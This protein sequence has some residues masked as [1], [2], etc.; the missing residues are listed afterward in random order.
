M[1]SSSDS[2]DSRKSK[3]KRKGFKIG[4]SG[5]PVRWDGEDWTFYKHAMQNAFE[6]NFLDGIAKFDETEDTAWDDVKKEE[7]K[8]KQAEIKILIQGSLSMRLAK[9]VMSKSTGTEMWQELVTIYEGK[10]NPAMTAQKVYRLQRELRRTNLR[11]KDDVRGHLYKLF[12]IKTQLEDLGAPVN[13]LQ[14]VDRMLRSLPTAPCYNELRRKKSTDWGN[15]AFGNKQGNTAHQK[16]SSAKKG[17]KKQSSGGDPNKKSGK[18]IDHAQ[19]RDVVVGDVVKRVAKDYDPSRWYFDTGSNAYITACKEY[20]TSMQSMENSD[21]NPTISGFA[22]GV[23]AKAE[24][25]GTIMLAAMIDEKMVFLLVED[26]LYVP[27]AGCNLFSPGLALDQGFQMTWDSDARMFGMSKEGTEVIRTVYENRLWTFNAHNIGSAITNKKKNAVKKHVFANFAITDGVE[28]IDVWHERLGHTCPEYIRLMVDRGMAKG[29]MLKRRGKIDCADCHFG[30]QRRKT[31]KKKLGR[32]IEKVNDI[33]Y[34]DLLIPGANNGSQYSAVLVVMDGFSRYVKIFLLKSKAEGEVNKYMQEYIAWAERQHG[35]RVGT[36][37]TREWSEDDDCEASKNLVRQ[38]LTDK[39]QEFC[40]G[41]MAKWYK[42]KGIVHTKVGP[43]TS[44][45][46]PVERTH[47]TLVDMVKTMMHQSGLPASFWT[48]ALE[49][50][51]YVKN[52]VFC[53]GA[54]CTPYEMMFDSKPDIHH[55]RA[56]GSLAYCYTPKSKLKKFAMNCKMGFLIGYR[57]DVVG[58]RV[59]FPTEHKK[60][61]VSDVKINEAIKYKDRHESGYKGKVNK[62]LQTFNEFINEGEFDNFAAVDHDGDDS[63]HQADCDAESERCASSNIDMEDIE[64]VAGSEDDNAHGVWNGR[65]RSR[66]P[67]IQLQHQADVSSENSADR[68]LW[69]EILRASSLPDYDDAFEETQEGEGTGSRRDSD[70]EVDPEEVENNS[71][72]EISHGQSDFILMLFVYVPRATNPRMSTIR[73]ATESRIQEQIP[74]AVALLAGHNIHSGSPSQ[75]FMALMQAR[76]PSDTP[77]QALLKEIVDELGAT[78]IQHLTTGDVREKINTIDKHFRE[79]VD[80]QAQTGSGITS[81]S[82]LHGE[83]LKRCPYYYQ[84]AAVFESRPSAPPLVTSDDIDEEDERPGAIVQRGEKRPLALEGDARDA[85]LS[86]KNPIEKL[87]EQ[88]SAASKQRAQK[89]R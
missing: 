68:E 17:T 86:R 78:G 75:L 43:N 12:D 13:D 10:S 85:K 46:N 7:F 18:T 89:A 8:K 36:V 82:T 15:N 65:L 41:A 84:L 32:P 64:S 52:R 50:A 23:G 30:K 4:S 6:K 21:W 45:L 2:D 16:Q 71:T 53:K 28:D 54:G 63:S 38:V 31:F 70:T 34:A 40:N 26:V 22:D 59:Y 76:M 35:T 3:S 11:G 25:F 80:F 60:G 9:Q 42:K 83:I 67:T 66:L 73:R 47:Q 72:T 27:S 49:T 24:G 61:F 14:M 69:D 19:K 29:I 88:Q 77:I 58:C 55:I 57:E 44:Q 56:F 74:H 33:V 48:S 87:L 39:G 81:E 51:V 1:S 5:T 62:W 37:I 20:F 79:A